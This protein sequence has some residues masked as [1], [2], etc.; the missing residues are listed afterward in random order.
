M[1]AAYADNCQLGCSFLWNC[2][3]LASHS[4]H[5]FK[6]K[7]VLSLNTLVFFDTLGFLSYLALLI[8]N[9]I[10]IS[11]LWNG[12]LMLYTYNSVPWMVCW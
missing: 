3:D 11:D 9:G 12:P 7:H 10:I 8:A 6:T 1:K 5:I 4:D 2:V